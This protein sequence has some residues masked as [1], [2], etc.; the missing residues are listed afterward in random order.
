MLNAKLTRLRNHFGIF[1]PADWQTVQPS[2]ILAQ[3]GIGPKTLD[4]IRLQLANRGLTLKGDKTPEYWKANIAEVEIVDPLGD[5]EEEGADRGILLPF[6]VLI[7]SAEQFPFTFDGMKTDG[8][9]ESRRPLIVPTERICLGRHPDS[10]GDY[11]TDV[12]QGRCHIERKSME[13]AQGTILG[14][15]RDDD[16]GSTRRERFEQELRNLAEIEAGCVV[17]ECTFD[18]LVR[19][20]PETKKRSAAQN[21]KTLFRSVVAYQQ[22]YGVPWLFCENRRMAELATFRWLVRWAEK[23]T[24]DRK[25]E[26]RE[27]RKKEEVKRKTE[28]I[29]ASL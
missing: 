13:D 9:E 23:R 10:L 3:D 7:D 25:K 27:R 26:E 8:S 16:D 22:D 11:S 20:A 12:G 2:W 29:L 1:K 28:E 17:V 18:D 4:Y 24:E 15:H 5:P 6:T 21:S 19:N 14:F